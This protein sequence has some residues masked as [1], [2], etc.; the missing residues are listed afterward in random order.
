MEKLARGFLGFAQRVEFAGDF[1]AVAAV[2]GEAG[3]LEVVAGDEA[4]LRE[5]RIELVALA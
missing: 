5:L 1:L 3:D 2:L 4:D